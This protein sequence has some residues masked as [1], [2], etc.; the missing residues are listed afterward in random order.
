VDAAHGAVRISIE[1][2][3]TVIAREAKQSRLEDCICGFVLI[4]SLSL[5]MTG[6]QPRI[7]LP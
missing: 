1:P 6:G 7:S 2:I 5:A 3:P 4:A